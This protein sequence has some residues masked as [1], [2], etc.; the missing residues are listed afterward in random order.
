MA[1]R[2]WFRERFH[3]HGV[4]RQWHLHGLYQHHGPRL[5]AMRQF[6][7]LSSS[8]NR[9]PISRTTYAHWEI[10]QGPLKNVGE[11]LKNARR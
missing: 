1:S 7:G 4:R 10:T 5:D 2:P 11:M 6:F 9:P 8:Q 3:A